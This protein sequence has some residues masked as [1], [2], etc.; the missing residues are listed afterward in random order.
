VLG[1]NLA[2]LVVELVLDPQIVGDHAGDALE[3]LRLVVDL[4][5]AVGGQGLDDLAREELDLVGGEPHRIRDGSISP[6]SAC[7]P[8][9]R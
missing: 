8:R 3:D 5:A 2:D 9:R 6:L 4:K 1:E 7:Y